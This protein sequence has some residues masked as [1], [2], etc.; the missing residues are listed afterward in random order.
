MSYIL[1]ALKKSQQEREL[2]KIPDLMFAPVPGPTSRKTRSLWLLLIPFLLLVSAIALFLIFSPSSVENQSASL[3]GLP[4]QAKNQPA[5]STPVLGR[6]PS[7]HAKKHIPVV[8]LS[9][10]NTKTVSAAATQIAD[11]EKPTRFQAKT[12]SSNTFS[13]I[14]RPKEQITKPEPA[15]IVGLDVSEEESMR[16]R[17]RKEELLEI[18]KRIEMEQAKAKKTDFPQVMLK[19]EFPVRTRSRRENTEREI[20]PESESAGQNVVIARKDLPG[21][22]QA[23]PPGVRD[24]LPPRKI[25][26]LSYSKIANSR[27][28]RLNGEKI[29]EEEEQSNG[30]MVEEILQDGVI[31]R[32]DGH[33]F[34]HSM[35]QF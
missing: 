33:R 24:R 25:S 14:P 3:T 21:P 26:V 11:E 9:P 1:D 22:A 28:I 32:F 2:G 4:P 6:A 15:S 27:F 10:D 8:Q 23:L 35:Y 19:P 16:R 20:V 29:W 7:D 30:L 31:F 12:D 5:A 34:F 17:M 18:K 13:Q